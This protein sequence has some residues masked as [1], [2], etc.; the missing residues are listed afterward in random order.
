MSNATEAAVRERIKILYIMCDY[1]KNCL[2]LI[3]DVVF[4]G[5]I[6]YASILYYNNYNM[7][8]QYAHNKLIIFNNNVT[9]TVSGAICFLNT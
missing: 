4:G 3:Q 7:L 2:S 1:V 5:K 6:E 9:R 8:I